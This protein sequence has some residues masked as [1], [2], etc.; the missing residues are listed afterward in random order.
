M[1]EGTIMTRTV[2][3]PTADFPGPPPFRFELPEGW[4][5]VPSTRADAMVVGPEAEDGVYPNVVIANHRV[6]ATDDSEA[7]LRSMIE[8]QIRRSGI[9]IGDEVKMTSDA[10]SCT[11]RFTRLASAGGESGDPSVTGDPAAP[12][13]PVRIE[14][15]LNLHYIAGARVAHVLAATGTYAPSSDESRRVVESII[16]SVR[17]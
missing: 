10:R 4:R 9:V 13:E 5:A 7:L 15:S 2:G 1:T 14:Q 12:G 11:V 8:Q 16:Q 17:C 3:F 6:P